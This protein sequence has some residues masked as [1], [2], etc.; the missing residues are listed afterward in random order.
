M[1]TILVGQV[2][3]SWYWPQ[4]HNFK[5]RPRAFACCQ[6]YNPNTRRAEPRQTP[7]PPHSHDAASARVQMMTIDQ[8]RPW[9]T[10]RPPKGKP[11]PLMTVKVIGPLAPRLH[12]HMGRWIMAEGYLQVVWSPK[13]KLPIPRLTAT[14]IAFYDTEK[15]A[16]SVVT[17]TTLTILHGKG[18]QKE[19]TPP[20]PDLID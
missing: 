4:E 11:W 6:S 17:S 13:Y 10:A 5:Q 12:A 14:D 19:P 9:K 18:G 8:Q 3:E 16:R 15:S 1:H 20:S 2:V 7:C